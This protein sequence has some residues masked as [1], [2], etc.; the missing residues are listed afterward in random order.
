MEVDEVED[1]MTTEKMAEI[2]IKVLCAGMSVANSSLTEFAIG[3][4]EGYAEYVKFDINKLQKNII[5]DRSVTS[6]SLRSAF[7][8][9]FQH[10][11]RLQMPAFS[12]HRS[13][14]TIGKVTH[15]EML[16]ELIFSRI[17]GENILHE[18]EGCLVEIDEAS[19]R[20]CGT[21]EDDPAS[22]KSVLGSSEGV[23]MVDGK[24]VSGMV[25]V[26]VV[27]GVVVVSGREM[28][29][30]GSVLCGEEKSVRKGSRVEVVEG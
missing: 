24:V 25:S 19:E 30:E 22:K 16:E 14:K 13:Q 5:N 10:R 18:F 7:S 15:M 21:E 23:M 29:S 11:M 1:V 20:N 9:V 3:S 17:K 6:A 12:S 26:I 2:P 4:A 28:G 27:S 8:L